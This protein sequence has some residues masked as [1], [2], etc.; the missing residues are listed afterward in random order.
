MEHVLEAAS[1]AYVGDWLPSCKVCMG[2]IEES[3]WTGIIGQVYDDFQARES[4]L[5]PAPLTVG[6]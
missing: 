6:S 3:A 5:D 2:K 1:P 4:T